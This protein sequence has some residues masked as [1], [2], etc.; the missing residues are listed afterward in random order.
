MDSR[1][2]AITFEINAQGSP[3]RFTVPASVAKM[4]GLGDDSYVYLQVWSHAGLKQGR[5]KMASGREIYETA[6][7]NVGVTA[8][9]GPNERLL[10]TAS[11][12]DTDI[13]A[14]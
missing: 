4:L 12:P 11:R 14:P 13:V 2:V 5:F 1:V 8:A 10:I 9:V 6:E 3:G 7:E